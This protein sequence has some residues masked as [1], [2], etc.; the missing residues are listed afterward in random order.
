M[1]RE[2]IFAITFLLMT[3]SL[4]G[5]N[6]LKHFFELAN[7]N[8]TV[9]ELLLL[10][11]WEVTSANDPDLFVA[12]FNYYYQISGNEVI[13]LSADRNRKDGFQILDPSTNKQ[14]GSLYSDVFYLPDKLGKAFH[15]INIGIEKYPDRLD[16]RFGKIYLL[17]VIQD[18]ATFTKEIINTVNH[19]AQIKNNWIWKDNKPLENPEDFMLS[20]VHSYQSQLYNTNIDSL[21]NNMALIAHAVLKYY[22]NH[23]ESINDLS[24]V[25]LI[26]KDYPK[27]IQNLLKAEKLAPSDCI[28][29]GNLAQ[30]YKLIGDND[31]AVKYLEQIIKIGTQQ[32]KEDA[33]M[34]L[35]AI[36]K[37]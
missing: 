12:W 23:I 26:Q 15:Y 3:D 7:K 20:S 4:C 37:N 13:H 11:N 8:D 18:Y 6:N 22:P 24:I 25:Y 34:R 21:L 28:V 31:N 19:S 27:A 33:Q 17:G 2:I 35:K 36:N 32:E 29:L 5:Q 16:M 30:A 14:V 9:N 10:K 1:K